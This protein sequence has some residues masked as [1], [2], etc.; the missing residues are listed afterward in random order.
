M[1]KI[2][3]IEDNDE[4]RDN[5]VEILE[6][7]MYNVISAPDG[8]AGVEKAIEHKPDLIICDIMMPELDGYG[9]LHMLGKNSNTANIPFIFLTAKTDKSDI[10]KGMN[11]GADD[12]LTKPFDEA[13]LL[14]AVET[15]LKKYDV[16]NREF[17][18]TL[19]GLN[20]FILKA[21]SVEELK[22]ISAN[23]KVR[24]FRKKDLIYLEG[25]P[26]S[27]IIFIIKE[28]NKFLII[29]WFYVIECLKLSNSVSY[30]KN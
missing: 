4:I 11:M 19:E 3:L 9:V 1:K 12:Y 29:L 8:K 14:S 26:I 13:E 18:R 23:L 6:L 20:D 24:N 17:S 2:L 21:K 28:P 22:Q 15:R 30:K 27:K 10:R 16:F 7:T 5:T 25:D